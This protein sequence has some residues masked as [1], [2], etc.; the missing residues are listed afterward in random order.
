MPAVEAGFSRPGDDSRPSPSAPAARPSFRTARSN[1]AFNSAR[2]SPDGQRLAFWIEEADTAVWVKHLARDPL[3]R[4]TFSGDDHAPVWSPDGRRV[5]FESGRESTHQVFVRASDGSGADRRVTAGEYHHYLND[6]SPDGRSLIYVEFHPR[7]G[8]DLWIV[9]VEG[10]PEPRPFRNTEFSERY[11]AFSL[12]GRWIAYISNETGRNEVY[13]QAVSGAPERTQISDGG[14]E[15]PAWS[16]ARDRLYYRAGSAMMS[17]TAA[18]NGASFEAGRPAVLFR[19]LYHYNLI[20][21][22]THDVGPDGRFVMVTLPDP[23]SA[24]RQVNVMLNRL[25]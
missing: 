15:E 1:R 6:W 12:D 3:T 8:A 20:P 9:N 16:R 11:A 24:P 2:F 21:S 7:T 4:L 17:V 13:V 18:T 23:A 19:G 22:R 10:K 25:R 14:G 5:A